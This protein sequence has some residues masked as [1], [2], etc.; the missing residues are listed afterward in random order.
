MPVEIE[1]K[2]LVTGRPWEGVVDGTPIRQGYLAQSQESVV[3]VR[4]SGR[5][6]W[7]T[8]KGPTR[9]LSRSEF[10]YEI[11]LD[12][13]NPLLE[14]CGEGIIERP[15]IGSRNAALCLSWMFSRVRMRAWS[16]LKWN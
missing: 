7:L 15:A 3:R 8:I 11:P 6:A 4:A 14:L 1:R 9:G 12:D 2:F 5:Q 16:W 13:A 10:E